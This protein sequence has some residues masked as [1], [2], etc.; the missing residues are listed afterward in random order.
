MTT[1]RKPARR[2]ILLGASNLVRSISTV[3]ETARELWREPVEIM[4]AIGHGRSY[5]QDSRMLGRKIPGIFPSALWKDLQSRPALPTV[6]LVT[7]VGND[8]GYGVSV[9]ELISW[10]DGCLTHLDRARATTIITE[11]PLARL[12]RMSERQFLFF[13]TLFFPRSRLTFADIR[14]RASELND[15]LL[16]LGERRKISVIQVSGA[17]Y[18]LD[19]IHLRRSSW[20]EAWPTIL[21]AWHDRESLGARPR[22]SF[23]RWAYLRSLAPAEH[24]FL[25]WKRRAAQ[26]SGVLRDGTTISFY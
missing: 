14:T 15:S 13:R 25:G 5:G 26:P 7:D 9:P 8:L 21:S 22:T 16:A 10:V 17:W 19:P 4:A 1:D 23:A 12:E 20:R 18:G 11:L 6:A 3:V 24:T 2:V